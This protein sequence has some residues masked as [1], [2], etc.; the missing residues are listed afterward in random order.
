[1]SFKR[2]QASPDGGRLAETI[3]E[4]HQ[5][6]EVSNI[7]PSINSIY[8]VNGLVDNYPTKFLIDSGAA[9]SVIRYDIVKGNLTTKQGGFAVSANG[10]PLD[11][12]GQMI[13][14]V[15]LDNF[16]TDHTF[17]VVRNLTVDCLL[18]ADFLKRHA[19]ILDC[20]RSTLMLGRGMQV[21]IPLTLKHQSN[22]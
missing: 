16:T 13:V 5:R 7:P 21:V 4:S 18:G 6:T 3:V 11:I 1:M 14:A 19:A 9:M 17:T 12:V 20:G 15:T 2:K 8:C 22:M 10:S